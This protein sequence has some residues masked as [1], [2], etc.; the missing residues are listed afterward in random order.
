LDHYDAEVRFSVTMETAEAPGEVATVEAVASRTGKQVLICVPRFSV[1][2]PLDLTSYTWTSRDETVPQ[3][4]RP[5][6][7]VTTAVAGLDQSNSGHHLAFVR[8]A[9]AGG[10]HLFSYQA[11]DK[12][13]SFGVG[14]TV[15]VSHNIP[16]V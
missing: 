10:I 8:L 1:T 9:S 11:V 5:R 7:D 13:N 16:D 4:F 2:A 15:C 3:R 6:E 14:S 12:G